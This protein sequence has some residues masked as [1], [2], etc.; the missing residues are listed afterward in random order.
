MVFTQL[1][2]ILEPFESRL[3]VVKNDE[4]EFYL[5]TTFIMKNKKPLYFGSVKIGKRYVSYH[6][7]PVYVE[8]A[9]LSNTTDELLK[10]MHGKSC[11][12]FTTVDS[13]LFKELG[14]LTSQ[15]FDYYQRKN[16]V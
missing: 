5:N 3:V 16:Y 13:I 6:L 4:K 14:T 9:L 10:H 2:A 8:P 12:N 11:F 7:M 15:G 1:K